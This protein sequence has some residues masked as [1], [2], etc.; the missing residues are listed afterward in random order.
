MSLMLFLGPVPRV[1]VTLKD[2][3]PGRKKKKEKKPYRYRR[4]P[5]LATL[6]IIERYL[7]PLLVCCRGRGLVG[8]GPSRPPSVRKVPS[9]AI[10]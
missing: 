7:S 3:A 5:R 2:C 9:L 10:R 8:P 1:R 4:L 6:E